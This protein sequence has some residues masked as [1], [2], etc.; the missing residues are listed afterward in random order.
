MRIK[1]ETTVNGNYL[2][3]MEK[4]D[5][6]LFEALL[7]KNAKVDIVTF[8][9]S[10]KGNRVHLKFIKPIQMEWI[11]DIIEHGSDKKQ[12]YF[13][14]EGTKLPGFL[15]YWKH[16]HI[17]RKLTENTS[18]IVDDITFHGP[19]TLLTILIYPGIYLGFLPRKKIY[20][21]YFS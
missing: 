11:S 18:V 6:E 21:Q 15:K 14:D 17:V 1:L 19:N 8:T 13:I 16:K 7:P 3:I 12:A 5:R 9:G 2:E 10:K 20:Q 4:F